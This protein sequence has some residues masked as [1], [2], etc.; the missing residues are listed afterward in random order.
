MCD[1]EIT[2][3]SWEITKDEFI[4]LYTVYDKTLDKKGLKSDEY[5]LEEFMSDVFTLFLKK[6]KNDELELI[7]NDT[8]E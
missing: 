6:L 8:L 7:I 4:K 3:V 2:G 1:D 5:S